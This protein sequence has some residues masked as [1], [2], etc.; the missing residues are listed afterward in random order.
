FIGGIV[1]SVRYSNIL[2]SYVLG[3]I[4]GMSFIGGIAGYVDNGSTV[5]YNAAINSA[6]SGTNNVN[7]IVGNI[8][9][10]RIIYTVSNNF[11]LDTMSVTGA[12]SGDEGANKT[13]D[14][15]KIKT[16]Y[17]NST[18]NGGLGWK[19]GDDDDNP[20]KMEEGKNND[21]PYFYWQDL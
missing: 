7:R 20:W 1:G 2:N 18:T 6:I 15:L 12:R 21:L 4:S 13:I 3:D 11:A 16:T 8:N 19:F 9:D 5:Q 10:N 17:S 14:E